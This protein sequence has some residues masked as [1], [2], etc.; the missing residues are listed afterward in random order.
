ME[1]AFKNKKQEWTKV[2]SRVREEDEFRNRLL[3]EPIPAL[4]EH[5]VVFPDGTNVA[6]TT[7]E[8]ADCPITL[9][10]ADVKKNDIKIT[11]CTGKAARE[12]SDEDLDKIAGG[13]PV[14]NQQITD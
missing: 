1:S 7:V 2:I 4:K 12:V 5:G 8:K 9:N 10:S 11:I 6:I 13:S 3:Q 14:V